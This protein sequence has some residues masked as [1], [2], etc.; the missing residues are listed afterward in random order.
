MDPYEIEIHDAWMADESGI[1][2]LC[3]F[4]VDDLTLLQRL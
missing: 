3:R 1:L 2:D 4:C